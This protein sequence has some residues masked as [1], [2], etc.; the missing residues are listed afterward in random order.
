M[1]FLPAAITSC[2][3][4][5]LSENVLSDA[6]NNFSIGAVVHFNCISG[7]SLIGSSVALCQSNGTWDTTV[8]TCVMKQP[9]CPEIKLGDHMNASGT[10]RSVGAEVILTCDKGYKMD[11]EGTLHCM[12]NAKWSATT[13]KCTST[14]TVTPGPQNTHTGQLYSE[15]FKFSLTPKPFA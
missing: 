2:L 11:G 12:E 10:N 3:P 13:P 14:S 6:S 4:L 15:N 5:L 8:P 7:Y 9:Q 1:I